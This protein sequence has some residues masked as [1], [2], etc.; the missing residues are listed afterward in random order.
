M[1]K[2]RLTFIDTTEG[3]RELQEVIKILESQFTIINQSKVY[4]GRGKS[5]YNN[6]YIDIEIKKRRIDEK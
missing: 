1:I 6:I 4:K 2:G 5:L 3:K